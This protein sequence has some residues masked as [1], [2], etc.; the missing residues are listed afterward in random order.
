VTFSLNGKHLLVGSN[1][2]TASLWDQ[3]TYQRLVSLSGQTSAVR[4]TSFSPDGRIALTCH[5]NGQVFFWQVSEPIQ[6]TL[7]GLYVAHYEVGSI[8]WIDNHHLCLADIGGS[9]GRPHVYELVLEGMNEK[10]N[11]RPL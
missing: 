5:A 4:M 2:G 9:S 7:L 8:Y 11:T 1:D 3:A 6:G 10:G